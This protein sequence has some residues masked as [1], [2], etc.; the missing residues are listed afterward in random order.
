LSV[1]GVCRVCKCTDSRPC[2]L[3][4]DGNI[5][6]VADDP[7]QTVPM[8]LTTCAWVEP[9]LCSGCVADRTPAL[10]YDADGKPLRGAP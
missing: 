4:A 7:N 2:V 10:L 8:G 9:D 6:D 1:A 5:V 3:D